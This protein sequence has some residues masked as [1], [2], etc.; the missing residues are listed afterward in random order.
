MGFSIA[1]LAKYLHLARAAAQRQRPL[2]HDR[3]MLLAA[4][5]AQLF[6]LPGVAAYCRRRILERNPRHLLARWPTLAE[7]LAAADFQTFFLRQHR[8][9]PL[10]KVE[11]MLERLGID[12]A[13]EEKTYGSAVEYAA[14]L[15]GTTVKVLEREKD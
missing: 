5:Q 11:R 15:L 9:Y 8:H 13:A 14:A 6:E 12:L 1:P 3:L 2:V 7:A 4:V 10:E